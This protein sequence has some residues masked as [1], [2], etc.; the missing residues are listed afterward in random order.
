MNKINVKNIKNKEVKALVKKIM[1]R[2]NLKK[3]EN[4]NKGWWR[5]SRHYIL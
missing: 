4:N 5:Q 3:N 1:N 2:Y